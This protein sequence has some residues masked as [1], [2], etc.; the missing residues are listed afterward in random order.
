MKKHQYQ[1]TKQF[2]ISSIQERDKA[3][4]QTLLKYW[5]KGKIKKPIKPKTLILFPC[6]EYTKD[7]IYKHS[8]PQRVI[9]VFRNTTV[10]Y[11]SPDYT[12]VTVIN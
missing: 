1:E 7:F 6:K 4:Y 11:L 10:I 5:R 9:G 2:I 3:L 8:L 12:N